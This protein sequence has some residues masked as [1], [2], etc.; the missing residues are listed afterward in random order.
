MNFQQKR[1]AALF[2]VAAMLTL[3][4]GCELI[5]D[6]DRSLIDGGSVEAGAFDAAVDSTVQSDAGAAD[7]SMPPLDTSMPVDTGT[8]DTGTPED[9]GKAEA[10]E[11]SGK[12]SGAA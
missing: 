8:I 12:E 6:F 5:V 1:R 11:D 2:T 9:S 4:V 7:T 3:G 10:G